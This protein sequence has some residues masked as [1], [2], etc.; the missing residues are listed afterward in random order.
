[1]TS[2]IQGNRIPS[3][4]F[5]MPISP[6]HPLSGTPIYSLNLVIVF[7]YLPARIYLIHH[8]KQWNYNR[9]FI[10]NPEN[11]ASENSPQ[12]IGEFGS[13]GNR[14]VVDLSAELCQPGSGMAKISYVLIM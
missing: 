1:M 13:A 7:S 4:Q 14:R 2:G 11:P 9:F 5:P 10:I 6:N 8:P 12:S 3:E